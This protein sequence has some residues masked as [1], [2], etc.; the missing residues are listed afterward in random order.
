MNLGGEGKKKKKRARYLL[1]VQLPER[2]LCRI[3]ECTGRG[4]VC[5]ANS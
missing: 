4:Q 3:R 5:L 1:L 2:N